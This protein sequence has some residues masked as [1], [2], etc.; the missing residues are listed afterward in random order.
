MLAH[1]LNGGLQ[2]LFMNHLV[3]LDADVFLRL[4]ADPIFFYHPFLIAHRFN[5]AVFINMLIRLEADIFSS[6][7]IPPYFIAHR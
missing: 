4:D 3:R 2:F 7:I 5:G 6:I 1:H